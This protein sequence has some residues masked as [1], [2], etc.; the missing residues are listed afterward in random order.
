MQKF[1]IGVLNNYQKILAHKSHII[2]IRFF[3]NL[4]TQNHTQNAVPYSRSTLFLF[5]KISGIEY[6]F[7][8]RNFKIFT[9]MLLLR[10]SDL[11]G[12]VQYKINN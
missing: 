4:K 1:V 10:L 7:N 6:L 9:N 5:N 2:D 8:K 12:N 3:L 11:S